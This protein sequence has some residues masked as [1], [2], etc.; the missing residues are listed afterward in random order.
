MAYADYDF[1]ANDFLGSAVPVD[2][3]PQMSERASAWIDTLTNDRLADGLPTNAR[4]QKRIKMAVCELAEVYYQLYL[5]E[6]QGIAMATMEQKSDGTTG[7]ITSKSA[8]SESVSYATPQQIGSGAQSWSKVYSVVGDRQKTNDLLL[9]TAL[10]LLMGIRT[11]NGIPVL[12][13][14]L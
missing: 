4:H 2:L 10:P 13:G 1:Y 11:D 5:A 8:G 12:Y 6:T 9:K 3:F 14:G 7:I